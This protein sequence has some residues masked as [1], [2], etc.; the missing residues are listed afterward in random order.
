MGPVR[1]KE[2][3]T[4][5]P[6]VVPVHSYRRGR[7]H[8]RADHRL[9]RVCRRSISCLDW[10]FVGISA[11]RKVDAEA[12]RRRELGATRGLNI[13]MPKQDAGCGVSEQTENCKVKTE[14][15]SF[16]RFN[17]PLRTSFLN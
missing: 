7:R 6:L 3:G 16:V 10:I 5:T 4:A 9:C 1:R 15:G 14:N 13:A 8:R 2:R 12:V 17:N 11:V